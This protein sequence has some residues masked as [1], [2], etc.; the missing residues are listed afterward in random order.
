[1]EATILD[2]LNKKM[3]T[4]LPPNFTA[5]LIR[6]KGSR[7]SYFILTKILVLCHTHLKADNFSQAD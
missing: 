7:I 2:K 4:I 3:E 6:G 1:M 5:S